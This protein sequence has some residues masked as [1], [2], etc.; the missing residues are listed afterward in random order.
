MSRGAGGAG[1]LRS[2]A[3]EEAVAEDARVIAL[4]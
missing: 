1:A 4:F 2:G 3:A